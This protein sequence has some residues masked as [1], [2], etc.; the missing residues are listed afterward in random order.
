V[1]TE[2]GAFWSANIMVAQSLFEKM[3]GFDEQFTI[4]AQEDQDLQ[5]RIQQQHAIVFVQQ[6]IVVHPV[7]KI[8]FSK[9]L[10]SMSASVSNWW[11]FSLKQHAV[12]PA[13]L[14]GIKSQVA[15]FLAN[16]KTRKWQ[17]ALLNITTIII[18]LPTLLF[19]SKHK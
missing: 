9:K 2:G 5:W 12:F 13:L 17:S 18:L 6:A 14:S 7:R 10:H 3:G 15:A 11:K 8:A 19:H 1:N 16:L 4:A